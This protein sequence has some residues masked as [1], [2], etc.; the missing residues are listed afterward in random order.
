MKRAFILI[1]GVILLLSSVPALAASDSV[2]EGRGG[3]ARA[4]HELTQFDPGVDHKDVVFPYSGGS[5]TETSMTL[6]KGCQVNSASFD[7][8]GFG[9]KEYY[10]SY[11][12]A[13]D[14]QNFTAWNGTAKYSVDFTPD[15][16]K[17]TPFLVGDYTNIANADS[18]WA[19]HSNM[20]HYLEVYQLFEFNLTGWV[21][22]SIDLYYVGFGFMALMGMSTFNVSIYN[23]TA[24]DW[25]QL[26][27]RTGMGATLEYHIDEDLGTGANYIHSTTK[28]MYVLVN[29]AAYTDMTGNWSDV[30]SDYVALNIT[31]SDIVLPSDIT[32]DVGNDGTNEHTDTGEFSSKITL[33]DVHGVS[34]A[35]QTAVDGGAGSDVI[36][37]IKATS[38]SLGRLRF[39]NPI[40]RVWP[41]LVKK[42]TRSPVPRK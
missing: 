18:M 22:D 37:K 1:V 33:G 38:A 3:E 2:D 6:P 34:T 39:S 30:Y 12:N 11:L 20:T 35:I 15:Q 26:Q 14:S 27:S 23:V 17:E 40:R 32:V 9:V 7:I 21:F 28:L 4:S 25:D 8:Q 42:A 10:T 41:F 24:T 36:V 29:A 19:Y 31:Q 13:T 5:N 16:L